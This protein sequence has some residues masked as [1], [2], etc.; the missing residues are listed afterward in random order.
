MLVLRW[1]VLEFVLDLEKKVFHDDFNGLFHFVEVALLL[2]WVH[3]GSGLRKVKQQ[4]NPVVIVV[5][6]GVRVLSVQELLA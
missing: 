5:E 2:G 6:H 1:R 3:G 4:D